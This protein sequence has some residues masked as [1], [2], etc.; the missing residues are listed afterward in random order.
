MINAITNMK[1][2]V[3]LSLAMTVSVIVTVPFAGNGASANAPASVF[4]SNELESVRMPLENQSVVLSKSMDQQNSLDVKKGIWGGRGI[5]FLVENSSA[6]IELDCGK[7][8]ISSRVRTRKDGKFSAIG[9]MTRSGPGPV[10]RDAPPR[11]QRVRFEG[12]VT[13]KQ[14]TVKVTLADSGDLV[15]DYILERGSQG[16]LT[17]CY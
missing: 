9:L 15:G 5:R 16:E 12:K 7:A 6:A 10:M 17:R 3:V 14:M 8:T 13:G 11:T 4:S 1:Y 2:F